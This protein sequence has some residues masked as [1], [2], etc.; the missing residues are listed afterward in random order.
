[1]S[2]AA[3]YGCAGLTLTEDERSFFTDAQPW[4]FILFARN[5][6]TPDQIRALT[7]ELRATVGRDDAPILID[8]E[9]GRVARLKPP[10]WRARPPMA[11]FG[12]L[13]GQ[14]PA[15]GVE[16]ARL[17][18]RLIAAELTA[19]GVNVDCLPLLDVPQSGAHDII[20]DRAFS[21]SPDEIAT[22]GR[23]VMEGLHAGGVL[24][25]IKHIPGHGRALADSHEELP[26]VDAAAAELRAVDFPPFAALKDA[27]MGMT[28]HIVYDALD[29]D[30]VA[31]ASPLIVNDIIRKEIGFDGLLMTD[32]LSMKALK[33]DFGDRTR[34]AVDAGCD[35]V[36]HC[37]GDMPEMQAIAAAVPALDGRAAER[38]AAA[39]SVLKPA[40]EIIV[41][42]AES[43][44]AN[45]LAP[46]V[47]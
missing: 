44:L 32:D 15:R 33:G 11:I 34:A 40:D 41:E 6:E 28:A 46:L 35:V 23:A 19:I 5:C 42:E 36:L 7:Q 25:V 31:T 24:S 45:L 38:A 9:G 21:T 30:R 4:G 37:N 43:R 16:A 39:L 13:Y 20:G 2:S 29:R 22:L 8:Q 10:H 12:S 3:I 1:M 47:S 14:D 18:A 26:R 17:N 27:P